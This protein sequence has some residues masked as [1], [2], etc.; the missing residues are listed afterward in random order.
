M[1]VLKWTRRAV[2]LL[3]C[4]GVFAS[5]SMLVDNQLRS[6][7][8]S[9][10]HAQLFKRFWH[11][12]LSALE[13]LRKSTLEHEDIYWLQQLADMDDIDSFLKLAELSDDESIRLGLLKRAANLGSAQGQFLWALEQHNPTKR[14]ALLKQSANQGYIRAQHVLANW[15]L[16]N[17]QKNNAAQWLVQTAQ[18]YVEDA[19]A[20]ANYYWNNEQTDL[21]VQFFS[22]A[23]A[24]GHV[25]AS[26][27]LDYAQKGA[28]LI[29]NLLGTDVL[30]FPLAPDSTTSKCVMRILP[31]ARSLAN[32][33]QANDFIA[34]LRKD[35]RLAHLP[36]CVS[37]PVWIKGSDF[38]CEVSRIHGAQRM[39]CDVRQL[40]DLVTQQNI[41][42]VVVFNP[43]NR[44]Y[45]DAGIMYL[46][47]LD[48]YSVFV[49]ELAHFAG[50]IDEY[51]MSKTLAKAHCE[52][53]TAPNLLFSGDMYYEPLARLDYWL[54]LMSETSTQDAGIYP[55]RTCN[56]VQQKS[57]KLVNS[58]TF[59]EFHDT[60]NIPDIYRRIWH[61]QLINRAHWYPVAVNIA[62][63]HE[64]AADYKTA[65]T[66]YAF[67]ETQATT[68][69]RADV[70]DNVD[71]TDQPTSP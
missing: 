29:S 36:M 28:N 61:D 69:P 52:Q 64:R 58:R 66:W 63:W 19:F 9:Q 30:F 35:R 43:E 46:D 25:R 39:R 32:Q 40:A 56:N 57:Y 8:I 24:L 6:D 42:H 7:D 27:F 38:N 4:C 23:H 11:G 37:D 34:Q 13:R 68:E 22:K 18:Y 50:F 48:T 20:L 26:E 17:G 41:T 60:D 59:M 33:V 3:L 65:Q 14:L 70:E 54:A 71:G 15:Y 5:T 62:R 53:R 16:L 45:V 1:Q 12:D 47:S 67:A 31:I 44:A 49:H 55:A 51:P 10:Y 2:I 21:A